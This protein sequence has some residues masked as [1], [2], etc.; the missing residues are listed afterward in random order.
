MFALGVEV[1]TMA[2]KSGG[3]GSVFVCIHCSSQV[4]GIAPGFVMKFCF[5]CGKEQISC[6]N[7]ECKKPFDK[8][9]D[10]CD[11]CNMPQSKTESPPLKPETKVQNTCTN[12]DCG[13]PVD[14]AKTDLCPKCKTSG[15]ED[16]MELQIV[17]INPSCKEALHSLAADTCKKCGKHQI[18]EKTKQSTEHKKLVCKTP[19]C[20]KVLSSGETEVCSKCKASQKQNLCINPDCKVQLFSDKSEMCHACHSSQNCQPGKKIS[21]N[22]NK[23][24]HGSHTASST[25]NVEVSSNKSFENTAESSVDK[26]DST[27]PDSHPIQTAAAVKSNTSSPTM[28]HESSAA[29]SQEKTKDPPSTESA[30]RPDSKN[31]NTSS[32]LNNSDDSSDPDEYKTPPPRRRSPIVDAKD[33]GKTNNGTMSEDLGRLSLEASRHRKHDRDETET[34][35]ADLS[36]S[37]KRRALSGNNDGSKVMSQPDKDDKEKNSDEHKKSGDQASGDGSAVQAQGIGNPNEEVYIS[38]CFFETIIESVSR[39]GLSIYYYTI[40]RVNSLRLLTPLPLALH[41][42][43]TTIMSAFICA[44]LCA[45]M[46][47]GNDFTGKGNLLHKFTAIRARH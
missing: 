41:C 17:C 44:L 42:R 37:S 19:N 2:E 9:M 22:R 39:A 38:C 7:P 33:D 27:V 31:S 30:S 3:Q 23:N 18:E 1:G 10:M 21:D 12:P 36:N 16:K 35:D 11:I 32:K 43:D 28:H 25:E 15:E 13:E 40:Q 24:G 34:E 5:M 14:G 4:P 20:K 26:N 47:V 29:E 45:C 6:I 8:K 46:L